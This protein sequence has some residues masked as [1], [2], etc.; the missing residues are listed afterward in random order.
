MKHGFYKIFPHVHSLCFRYLTEHVVEYTACFR[1][2]LEGPGFDSQPG[3]CLF[4]LFPSVAVFLRFL[5]LR[6]GICPEKP[7]RTEK[8]VQQS[9]QTGNR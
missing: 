5:T 9:L 2:N 7:L 3:G 6:T 1:L 8:Q 4:L